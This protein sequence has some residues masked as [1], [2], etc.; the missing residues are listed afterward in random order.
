M[1]LS[2]KVRQQYL[3]WTYDLNV[4]QERDLSVNT[5]DKKQF[6]D[7]STLTHS[8]PFAWVRESEKCLVTAIQ[9]VQIPATYGKRS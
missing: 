1:V 5:W 9:H 4:E 6:V 2:K 7:K 8:I 3:L